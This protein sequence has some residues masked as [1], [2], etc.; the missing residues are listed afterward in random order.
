MRRRHRRARPFSIVVVT[1][2]VSVFGALGFRVGRSDRVSVAKA[3]SAWAAAASA[4]YSHTRG[5][6]YQL[7]WRHSYRRG[8]VAGR[9][10]GSA[11]GTRAGRS[12]GH[13]RSA[14]LAAAASALA[15]AIPPAPIKLAPGTTI[16]KCVPVG[17]GVCEVLGPGVTGKPCPSASVPNPEG[18][19]VCV[20]RVLILAARLAKAPGELAPKRR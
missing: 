5:S 12:A 3:T 10:A 19:V 1:L 7:A 15:A 11:D 18:G 2:V 20:P 17:G 8:R 6:A 13:A 4:A 9:A 14:A 16:D